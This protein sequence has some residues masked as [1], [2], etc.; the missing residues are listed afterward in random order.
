MLSRKIPEI[1]SVGGARSQTAIF[2]FLLHP[3]TVLRTAY[4]KQLYSQTNGR[5]CCSSFLQGCVRDAT[6]KETRPGSIRRTV[7]STDIESFRR[8][9]TTRASGRQTYGMLSYLTSSGLMASLQSAYRVHHSTETA[10]LRVMADIL[11]TVTMA[12]T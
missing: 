10:V 6:F 7:V 11:Q 3:S 4:R 8:V 5:W 1:Y 2:A 12:S 9:Q